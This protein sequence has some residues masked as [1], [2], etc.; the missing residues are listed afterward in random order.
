MSAGDCLVH[1]M[2]IEYSVIEYGNHKCDLICENQPLPTNSSLEETS[3]K[4]GVVT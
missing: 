2:V 1:N 3:S 4:V